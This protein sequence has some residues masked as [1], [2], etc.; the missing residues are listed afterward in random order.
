MKYVVQIWRSDPTTGVKGWQQAAVAN[1]HSSA[2]AA[3]NF[4]ANAGHCARIVSRPQG[5]DRP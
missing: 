1:S 4:L 2:V 3:K 5:W